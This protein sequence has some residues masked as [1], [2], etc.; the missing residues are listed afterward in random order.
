MND[1]QRRIRHP[2]LR[3]MAPTLDGRVEAT[4]AVVRGKV[5]A[6]LVT[7]WRDCSFLANFVR[8]PATT[9]YVCAKYGF[10][11][12]LALAPRGRRLTAT[13]GILNVSARQIEPQ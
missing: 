12:L 11:R 7:L 4:G 10:P 8:Q 3:W 5:H 13:W 1:A 6:A 2:V 9:H